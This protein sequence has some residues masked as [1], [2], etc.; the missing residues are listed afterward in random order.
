M[1]VAATIEA[2]DPV[3]ATVGKSANR[4][5]ALSG[6]LDGERLDVVAWHGDVSQYLVNAFAPAEVSA[7]TLHATKATV[8]VARH[9]MPAAVGE[10]GLNALLAGQLTGVTVEVTPVS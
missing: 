3:A 6:L 2:L 10:R 4:V 1:A 7:V 8:A 9:L 5:R